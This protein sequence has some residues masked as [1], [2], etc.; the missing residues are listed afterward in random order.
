MSGTNSPELVTASYRGELE[1]V[2]QLIKNGADPNSED[3]HGMGRLLTPYPEVIEFLLA[4]GADPN[5]LTIES[6]DTVLGG[7][8]YF[9]NPDCIRLLLEAGADSNGGT[10]AAGETPLHGTLARP[11]NEA[12]EADRLK[13][14]K[15]LI[16]HGA[17]VNRQTNPGVPSQAFWRD[18]RTRGETPLHRAAAFA[19]EYTIRFLLGAGADKTIRDVN[20]DSPQSWASWHWRDKNLIDLLAQ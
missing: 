2:K 17:D 8:T 15:C 14:V 18:V 16:E 11:G 12:F 10:N 9:N 5:R 19:G 4:H 1:K 3:Q 13:I 20:G 6:G 7:S